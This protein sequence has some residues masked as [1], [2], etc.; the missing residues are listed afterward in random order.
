MVVS[1]LGTDLLLRGRPRWQRFAVTAVGTSAFD[2]L[3]QT[4]LC[5]NPD[6]EQP[7]A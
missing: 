1:A 2:F 4:R 6:P 3:F 7:R 5:Q